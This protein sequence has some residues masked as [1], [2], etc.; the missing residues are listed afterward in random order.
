MRAVLFAGAAFA[1]PASLAA[2]GGAG[3]HT[4]QNISAKNPAE[5]SIALMNADYDAELTS[6]NAGDPMIRTTLAG[7]RTR[8]VFYG[9]NEETN[10]ECDSIQL[11]TGFDRKE[12]WTADQALAISQRFRY[13][14]VRLDEEGDPFVSWDIY[15]GEG[16]PEEV[17]MTSVSI[18]EATVYDA[19]ELAFADEAA[20][21]ERDGSS[22]T[23]A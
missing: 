13:A 18:F 1:L 7:Y 9:C 4:T 3:D 2:Q 22:G 11:V 6:D 20:E 16:I 17:F 19:A 5:M 21:E 15:L 10:D 8:I 23:D 12:P 14:A